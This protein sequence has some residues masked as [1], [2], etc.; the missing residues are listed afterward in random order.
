MNIIIAGGTGFIGKSISEK[1]M[2]LGH[3]I[4]IVSRANKNTNSESVSNFRIINWNDY[5]NGLDYKIDVIIN[6]SGESIGSGRWNRKTKEKIIQSRISATSKIATAISEGKISPALLINASA[7]GYYGNRGDEELNEQS[8]LGGD[9]LANVCSLWEKE[10]S[11][12]ESAGVRVVYLRTGL[13]I[14]KSE[15][16]KKLMLPHKFFMGGPLGKGSQ[17]ISWIHIDDLTDIITYIIENKNIE[18]SI[19]AVSPNPVT[20]KIL[21]K[22]IGSL[23]NRPSW[24]KVPSFALKLIMGEMSDIILN[25]QKVIPQKLINHGYT[26]KYPLINDALMRLFKK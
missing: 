24:L 5:E 8:T 21:Q 10:A 17:W 1:L 20:M 19:N 18:G 23:M 4:T 14:G 15:A 12:A 25:S 11:S 7:I 6:L 16:V 9:F 22:T 13:V 3:H 26:Y 2:D